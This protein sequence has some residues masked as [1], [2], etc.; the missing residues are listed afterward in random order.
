VPSP[1]RG[2]RPVPPHVLPKAH[3]GQGALIDTIAIYS[4]APRRGLPRARPLDTNVSIHGAG[5]GRAGVPMGSACRTRLYLPL[6][7]P[8]AYQTPP[9]VQDAGH[10]AGIARL[11]LSGQIKRNPATL[12]CSIAR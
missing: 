2:R 10:A 11:V 1:S 12:E 9:D 8:C 4:R 6:A 3:P 7:P 5:P